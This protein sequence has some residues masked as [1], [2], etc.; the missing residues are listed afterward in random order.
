[1]ASD[2]KKPL[3]IT[4]ITKSNIKEILWPLSVNEMYGIGKKTAPKLIENNIKTIGDVANYSN[5]TVLRTILGRKALKEL[6][7]KMILK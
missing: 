5:Y 1:M 4:I 6:M 3:G 7:E 2:M